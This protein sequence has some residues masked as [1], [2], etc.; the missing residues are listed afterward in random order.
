MRTRGRSALMTIQS[1]S[2]AFMRADFQPER[3]GLLSALAFN[4]PDKGWIDLLVP[5]QHPPSF[6]DDIAFFGYFYMVP[7]ANRLHDGILRTPDQEYEFPIGL[8]EENLAI[9][10]T[11]WNHQWKVKEASNR[12]VKMV[13]Q[14]QN[15]EGTYAFEG[16]LAATVA[17]QQLSLTLTLKNLTDHKLP[18][19][20]G[21]HPWFSDIREAQVRFGND[22][23]ANQSSP[24]SKY[25][26]P[27][28]KKLPA[29]FCPL[30][31]VG[32]DS[33]F[34]DWD[35]NAEIQFEDKG[36]WL[37]LSGRGAC[38]KL[39]VFVMNE[40]NRFCLE[41]V[42]HFPGDLRDSVHWVAPGALLS[43]TMTLACQ[44]I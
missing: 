11:G 15:P 22:L 13:H 10:G 7:F 9:H 4:H 1:I 24:W 34:D 2:T 17:E 23:S 27:G 33:A 28:F 39:H 44:L 25:P 20:I 31:Y 26:Q 21:F 18:M 19:G 38:N 14:W 42:S 40:E 16:E 36:I 41:P 32:L 30:D 12:N 35:G 43:G 6:R 3:G 8:E 5:E 29:T 37:N